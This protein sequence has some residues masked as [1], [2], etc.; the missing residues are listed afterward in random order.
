MEILR[1]VFLILLAVCQFSLFYFTDKAIAKERKKK[2]DK[3]YG[4]H[5]C[6]DCEGGFIRRGELDFI[7]CPFCGKEL[8]QH[9]AVLTGNEETEDNPFTDF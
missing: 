1:I 3:I 4:K 2:K 5:F 7:Y 9:K 8:T 6:N